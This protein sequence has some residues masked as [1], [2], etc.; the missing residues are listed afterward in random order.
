MRRSVFYVQTSVSTPGPSLPGLWAR[1]PCLQSRC[2]LK[3]AGDA[4]CGARPCV[5]SDPVAAAVPLPSRTVSRGAGSRI[6]PTAASAG[7]LVCGSCRGTGSWEVTVTVE[8]GPR[9]LHGDSVQRESALL[10]YSC[11]KGLRPPG[12][13]ESGAPRGRGRGVDTQLLQQH[14]PPREARDAFLGGSSPTLTGPWVLPAVLPEI[15]DLWGKMSVF[16]TLSKIR[17][18]CKL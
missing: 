17:C 7:R 4:V 10:G 1:V 8:R 5:P 18:E 13:P 11:S 9:K 6:A 12:A 16:L 3:K 2:V 14:E 15:R